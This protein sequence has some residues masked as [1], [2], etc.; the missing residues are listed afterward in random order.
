MG[1]SFKFGRWG[2]VV[3]KLEKFK[4]LKNSKLIPIKCLDCHSRHS[5]GEKCGRCDCVRKTSERGCPFLLK[6]GSAW[7]SGG[8][9]VGGQPEARWPGG[10]GDP[11]GGAWMLLPICHLGLF[12]PEPSL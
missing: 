1:S 4:K 7:R 11:A 5:L 3:F 9:V 10:L 6:L 8:E 12:A 2:H